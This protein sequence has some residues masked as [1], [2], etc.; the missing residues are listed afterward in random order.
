VS[1]GH[2]H[3]TDLDSLFF[4]PDVHD[5]PL[6]DPVYGVTIDTVNGVGQDG[7]RWVYYKAASGRVPVREFID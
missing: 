3:D 4:G 1:L 5:S 6:I 2:P 7:W